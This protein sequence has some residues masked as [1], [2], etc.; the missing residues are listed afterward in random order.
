MLRTNH[1]NMTT[2]FTTESVYFIGSVKVTIFSIVPMLVSYDHD[3]ACFI[4]SPFMR[5]SE[6]ATMHAYDNALYD[7]IEHSHCYALQILDFFFHLY[8]TKMSASL[9]SLFLST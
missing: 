4:L 6:S 9:K 7:I 1:L 3:S 2:S 8:S 5:L